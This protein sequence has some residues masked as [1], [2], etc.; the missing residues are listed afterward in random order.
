MVEDYDDWRRPVFSHRR[1]K[2]S[3]G[4]CTARSPCCARW[5]SGTRSFPSTRSRGRPPRSAGSTTGRISMAPS[6]VVMAGDPFSGK[7]ATSG[8][9]Q[10]VTDYGR[11]LASLGINGCSINNVNADPRVLS[12]DSCRR[13]CVL[14][15]PF[16]PWGVKV[17]IAVDFGS[18]RT[19]GGL[20]HSIRSIRPLSH[21]GRTRP[22]RSTGGS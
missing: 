15:K 10:P 8:R 14:P 2:R 1:R 21:F 4:L 12:P 22:M 13:S 16:G 20:R 19:V 18:P 17:A 5:P 6:N 11:M 3:R 7:R 9:S